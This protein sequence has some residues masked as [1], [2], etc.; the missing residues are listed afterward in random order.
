MLDF[1]KVFNEVDT[2]LADTGRLLLDPGAGK[3]NYEERLQNL[4]SNHWPDKFGLLSDLLKRIEVLRAELELE[5]PT[6]VDVTQKSS[7]LKNLQQRHKD[8]QI[9]LADRLKS[10]DGFYDTH[11]KLS[12]DLDKIEQNLVESAVDPDKK[13]ELEVS[14]HL[15]PLIHWPVWECYVDIPS[16]TSIR[17]CKRQWATGPHTG[18]GIFKF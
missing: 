10:L 4:N 12:S 8:L 15:R 17:A 18:A 14:K 13:T 7:N 2:S 1:D 11:H 9:K 6:A 16:I 3:E 5:S